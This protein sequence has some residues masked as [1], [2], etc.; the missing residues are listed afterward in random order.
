MPCVINFRLD[1]NVCRKNV[2]KLKTIGFYCAYRNCSNIRM[3]GV[4][5]GRAVKRENKFIKRKQIN[6]KTSD[7]EGGR[8]RRDPC[9]VK[10]KSK[11]LN[12]VTTSAES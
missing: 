10:A 5:T 7:A 11:K 1:Y 3:V 8:K 6:G 4:R 2:I 12:G 9:R